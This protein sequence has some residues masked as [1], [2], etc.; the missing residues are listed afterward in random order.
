[1]VALPCLPEDVAV[2]SAV[3]CA[4]RDDADI[5][6]RA[7]AAFL[8]GALLWLASGVHMMAL[9]WSLTSILPALCLLL[10]G[11]PWLCAAAFIYDQDG[12]GFSGAIRANPIVSDATMAAYNG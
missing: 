3:V 8:E 2:L 7:A 12:F 6:R 9:H 4:T 11:W 10:T 1:V 5:T